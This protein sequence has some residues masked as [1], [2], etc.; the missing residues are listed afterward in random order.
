MTATLDP[1]VKAANIKA[2]ARNLAEAAARLEC[3]ESQINDLAHVERPSAARFARLCTLRFKR[4]AAERTERSAL[5]A[6]HRAGL[7]DLQEYLTE[8]DGQPV[9]V[10]LDGPCVSLF[11]D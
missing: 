10:F 7:E 8:L 11:S 4:S 5:H 1:R 9:Y 2:A 3:I 6:A